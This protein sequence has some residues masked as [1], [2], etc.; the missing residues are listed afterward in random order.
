MPIDARKQETGNRTF[1]RLLISKNTGAVIL[2]TAYD[3]NE[4]CDN[5]LEKKQQ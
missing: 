4:G 3:A 1:P 2:A 5:G